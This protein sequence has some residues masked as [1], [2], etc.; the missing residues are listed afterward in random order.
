MLKLY[1]N[2]RFV[3]SHFEVKSFYEI[4]GYILKTCASESVCARLNT[5]SKKQQHENFSP[6]F[7]RLGQGIVNLVVRRPFSSSSMESPASKSSS[8]RRTASLHN[9]NTVYSPPLTEIKKIKI[10]KGW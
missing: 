1:E 5:V 3:S 9:M 6:F 8:L 2:L 4:F 10:I 7:Q